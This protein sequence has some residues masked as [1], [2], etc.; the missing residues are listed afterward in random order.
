MLGFAGGGG[1][2]S[3][4]KMKLQPEIILVSDGLLLSCHSSG[5]GRTAGSHSAGIGTYLKDIDFVVYS[6]FTSR[7]MDVNY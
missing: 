5:T 4:A 7:K 6:L 1:G 2:T 3:L